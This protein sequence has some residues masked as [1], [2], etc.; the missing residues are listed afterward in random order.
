[1]APLVVVQSALAA[2]F[3][4]VDQ[5]RDGL[6]KRLRGVC[7]VEAICGRA[8]TLESRGCGHHRHAEPQGLD[9][10]SLHPAAEAE[11]RDHDLH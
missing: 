10:L 4:I 6:G 3:G 1:M 2:Q 5:P 8:Q 11:R 9:D 7:D